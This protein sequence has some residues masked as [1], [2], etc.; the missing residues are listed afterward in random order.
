MKFQYLR[1]F[2]VL[3]AGLVAIILNMKTHKEVTWSLFIVLVVLIIF[4]FL[5]TLLLEIFQEVLGK[6]EDEPE[7]ITH[8]DEDEQAKEE[9]HVSFDEDENELE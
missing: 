5:A 9:V 3:V 7:E 2:I 6:L 1:A 8:L 4:Y